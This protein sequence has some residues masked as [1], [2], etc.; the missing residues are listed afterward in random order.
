MRKPIVTLTTDFGTKDHFAAVMK[1][2]ILGIAPAA[3]IIDISHEVDPFEISE[4]AFVIASAHRY[5]PPKT[6]HVVVVDPGVGSAR[7]PI[8]IEAAGQY[9][10]G[11]DNGVLAMVYGDIPHKARAITNDKYYLQPLSRT[12]HGRDIFAPVA[13][14][15]AKG[16]RPSALGK[17]I[18]DHLKPS[19]WRPQQTAKRVWMG[20]V[21]HID[22]FGN[23]ITNLHIEQF[24]SVQVRPFQMAVGTESLTRL[25][26][27][28]AEVDPGQPFVIVGSS[29]YLEVAVNQGSAA[30]VLGCGTGAPCELTLY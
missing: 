1:A 8:L 11:P 25:A 27:T 29:G 14:H 24:G 7:R 30:R 9:F 2:V 13:A 15:V 18:Q 19:F 28:Y 3:R 22:R 5:F 17:L 20:T 4:G 12:F 26:L 16:T 21:L 10:I 23:L 6:V